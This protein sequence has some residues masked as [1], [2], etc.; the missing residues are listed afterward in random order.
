VL[1][2]RGG[3]ELPVEPAYAAARVSLPPSQKLA[4]ARDAQERFSFSL[5]RGD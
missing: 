2:D 5:E 3:R 1:V 4:L